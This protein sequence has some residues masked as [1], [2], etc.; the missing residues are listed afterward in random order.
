MTVDLIYTPPSVPAFD[1]DHATEAIGAGGV[2]APVV[3]GQLA[4]MVDG[5]LAPVVD[6]GGS[7]DVVEALLFSAARGNHE[8]FVAL[9]VRMAGLVR[10]NVRRVLRDASR[11]E[12]V[13]QATFA[14]LLED[15][16]DFDP[17]HDSAQT[18]LLRLAHQHVLDGLRD[19]D[20]RNEPNPV[21]SGN[22]QPPSVLFA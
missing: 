3:D 5:Q 9:K 18:W 4:P 19:T 7:T 15:V 12:A 8:S 22:D 2:A 6:A 20:D 17:H 21:D 16:V 10:I 11:S 13:T 14:T 1:I